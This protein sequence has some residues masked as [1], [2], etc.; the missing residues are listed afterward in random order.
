[1]DAV[2][3]AGISNVSIVT[4]PLDT[5]W[6]S[7]LT[8]GRNARTGGGRWDGRLVLHAVFFAGILGL[9]RHRGRLAWRGLG[10]AAAGAAAP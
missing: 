10:T 6:Q 1:M 7:A 2:K 5:A 8:S 9:Q 3:Q 4:Q